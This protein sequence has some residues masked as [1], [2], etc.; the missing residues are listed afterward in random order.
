ML[1]DNSTGNTENIGELYTLF[2]EKSFTPLLNLQEKNHRPAAEG[3]NKDSNARVFRLQCAQIRTYVWAKPAIKRNI[4]K[5]KD[6][7]GLQKF[8]ILAD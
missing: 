1:N 4:T 7:V 2:C 8:F 3:R 5:Q 6:C